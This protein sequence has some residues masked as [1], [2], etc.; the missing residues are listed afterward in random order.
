VLVYNGIGGCLPGTYRRVRVDDTL[1]HELCLWRKAATRI[2]AGS[3]R[4][5]DA[6]GAPSAA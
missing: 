3:R 2:S 1:P 6:A 5:G 4:A